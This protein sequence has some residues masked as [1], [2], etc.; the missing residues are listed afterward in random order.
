MSGIWDHRRQTLVQLDDPRIAALD[1]R[2][3]LS[4]RSGSDSIREA[5][6]TLPGGDEEAAIDA[7]IVCR[8]LSIASGAR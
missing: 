5:I 1:E 8:A 2:A 4:G 7:A 6:D 3:A